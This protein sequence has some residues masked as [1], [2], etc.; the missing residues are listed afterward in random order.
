MRST[1]LPARLR[2]VTGLGLVSAAL[3]C[4]SGGETVDLEAER[5][6][7]LAAD[8]AFAAETAERGGDGWADWFAEDGFM[9]PPA[10][11]IEGREA[12]RER[13]RP[14]FAPGRPR[15]VWDPDQAVVG[16]GGDI[17][18]TLGRWESVGQGEAGADTVLARGNYVSI[19]RKI[20]GEGWRVAV[21]IGNRDPEEGS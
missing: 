9:Y 18:Y 11:R 4:G 6:A 1:M 2:T 17:G 14:A 10:G 7:L 3:G 16:S 19:W 15:L 12:I 5:E 20:P 21:D 8:R 13:M